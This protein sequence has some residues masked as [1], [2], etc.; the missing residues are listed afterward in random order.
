MKTLTKAQV[1]ARIDRLLDRQYKLVDKLLAE[2][3][4]LQAVRD[5]LALPE[6]EWVPDDD[7]MEFDLRMSVVEAASRLMSNEYKLSDAFEDQ[8]KIEKEERSGTRAKFE[9][10]DGKAGK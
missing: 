3:K 8:E 5:A 10:A 4:R 9:K 6:L 1:D 7:Q 2:A